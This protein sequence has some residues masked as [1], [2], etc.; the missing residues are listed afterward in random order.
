MAGD[1]LDDHAGTV[2]GGGV[3]ID[4]VLT[5]R[6]SASPRWRSHVAYAEVVRYFTALSDAAN[7]ALVDIP[8]PPEADR[9]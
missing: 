1:A 6:A 2:A 8:A 4:A 7:S 5:D 3:V 9:G